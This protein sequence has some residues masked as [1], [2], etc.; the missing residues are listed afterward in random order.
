MIGD[1][2]EFQGLQSAA[3]LNGTKGNLVE[4]IDNE[5]RWA[6][7]LQHGGKPVKAKPKTL[8]LL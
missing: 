7:R 5:H 3:Y 4:F 1:L 6:V 8:K 2:V